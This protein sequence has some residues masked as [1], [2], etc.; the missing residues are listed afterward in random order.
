MAGG[1]WMKPGS[2]GRLGRIQAM[3]R[4][5]ADLGIAD[6]TAAPPLWKLFWRMGLDVP[7]PMFMG[8]G[9]LALLMG[10]FFG[11]FW[12]FFMWLLMWSRQGMP[13]WLVFAAAALAGTLFGLAMAFHFRRLARKHRLLNWSDHGAPHAADDRQVP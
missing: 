11:L 10:G 12:G 2:Q 7:P 6:S 9:R 8:F 5:L 1:L 13:A 4:Q 3:R